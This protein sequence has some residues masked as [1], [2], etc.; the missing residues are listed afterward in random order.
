M[1]ELENKQ[2]LEALLPF[3]LNG[4]LDAADKARLESALAEDQQLREELAFAE[5]LQKQIQQLPEQSPGEFG[6]KRL[7]R[8]L[9][10]QQQQDAEQKREQHTAQ[11]KK[12][13]QFVA[14]AASLML[15]L[16][17][18]TVVQK[19]DDYRAASGNNT[20]QNYTDTVSVTFTSDATELQIRQLLLE[21]N[22][23][24]INGPSAIG[25]YRLA[26]T[27]DPVTSLQALQ[28]RSDLVES[29]QQ[30]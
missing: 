26:L 5:I 17:T 15:V 2:E 16:Q 25:L 21:H 7:Q 9:N 18:V 14:I 3:Y 8:S 30:D 6:L 27:T 10:Q 24:I 11:S 29:I 19:S 28:A 22:I 20:V 12:G 23:V 4:T 1:T 13:W